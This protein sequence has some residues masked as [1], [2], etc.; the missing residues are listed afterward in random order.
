MKQA[1]GIVW[2]TFQKNFTRFQLANDELWSA[3]PGKL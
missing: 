2:S 3:G 1:V